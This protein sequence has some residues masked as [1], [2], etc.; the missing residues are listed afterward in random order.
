MLTIRKPQMDALRSVGDPAIVDRLM[1]HFLRH[2]A[3]QCRWLGE[4]HLRRALLHGV[5]RARK[6]EFDTDRSACVHIGLMFGLGSRFDEDPQLPWA[7]EALASPDEP[8]RR[9]EMLHAAAMRYFDRIGGR[10]N[11]AL[12]KALVRIRDY[13]PRSVLAFPR[14]SVMQDL[15]RLLDELYPEKAQE[16]GAKGVE[17]LVEAGWQRTKALGMRDVVEGATVTTLMFMLGSHFDD[18]PL[19]PWAGEILRDGGAGRAARLHERAMAFLEEVGLRGAGAP[20][21]RHVL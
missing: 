7:A 15:A 20:G 10:D 12:V 11:G 16:L 4:S 2:H 5:E 14:D 18:D 19:H 6:N 1:P 17:D 3:A 21:G 9:I 13:A 8:A